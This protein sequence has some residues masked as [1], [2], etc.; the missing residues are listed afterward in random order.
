LRP[1]LKP[2]RVRFGASGATFAPS[3]TA[4]ISRSGTGSSAIGA[5]RAWSASRNCRSA[6]I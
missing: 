2:D 1:E 5:N 6:S 4:A 3:R